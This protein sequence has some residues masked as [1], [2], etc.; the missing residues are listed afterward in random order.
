M[1]LLLDGEEDPGGHALSRRAR[2]S[3]KG[4]VLANG[5]H[6][7]YPDEHTVRLAEALRIISHILTTGTPPADAPWSIDR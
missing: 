7:E 6:D 4:F 1:V 3:S 5:Q 2:G